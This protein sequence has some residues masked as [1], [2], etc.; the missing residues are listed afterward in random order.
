[1]RTREE[2]PG[3]L[4]KHRSRERGKRAREHTVSSGRSPSAASTCPGGQTARAGPPTFHTQGIRR[5]PA[6]RRARPGHGCIDI[7]GGR[8]I[9]VDA[10]YEPARRFYENHG[11]R[12]A[13]SRPARLFRKASDVAATVPHPT[14]EIL[15]AKGKCDAGGLTWAILLGSCVEFFRALR[16]RSNHFRGA[17]TRLRG[18]VVRLI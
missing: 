11:F 2:R 12:P 3:R 7:A 5:Q 4:V 1:L 10:I 14:P 15:A 8:L 13:P 6:A 17:F 18:A 9:A 16:E